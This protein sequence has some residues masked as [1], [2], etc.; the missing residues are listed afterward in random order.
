MATTCFYAP[1]SKES[2]IV[3]FP[4]PIHSIIGDPSLHGLLQLFRHL[5][6]CAQRH[7]TSYI[8]LDWLFIVVPSNLWHM[9]HAKAG[10][11]AIPPHPGDNPSYDNS[12]GLADNTTIHKMWQHAM[13]NWMECANMNK[14]LV[15]CFLSLIPTES[16]DFTIIHYSP[17]Q[18]LLQRIQY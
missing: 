5:I 3:G 2:M 15:K 4:T 13:K 14:A 1:T 6:K 11:L 17:I 12:E 10:F 16:N 7:Y 18:L 9:H 8:I